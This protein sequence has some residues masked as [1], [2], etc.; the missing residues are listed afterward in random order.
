M[1]IMF[2][3]GQVI[4][5]TDQ[6]SILAFQAGDGIT[7]IIYPILG[8]LMA[9]CGIARVPFGQWFK[10]A[11]RVV[12]GVYAVTWLFLLIAVKINWGPF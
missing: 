9:M 11:V 7:N 6:T 10:F 3:L 5:L 4:G 12:V 8:A 1:P 2:P